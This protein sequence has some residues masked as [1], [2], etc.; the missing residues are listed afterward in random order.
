[1]IM[2]KV[3]EMINESVMPLSEV[4]FQHFLRG[5]GGTTNTSLEIAENSESLP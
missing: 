4:L 2:N 5:N 1:M 3:L